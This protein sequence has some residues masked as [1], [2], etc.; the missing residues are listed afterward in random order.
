MLILKSYFFVVPYQS[1]RI[2][3]LLRKS[4]EDGL[5]LE[6]ITLF[7]SGGNF[8]CRQA[9]FLIVADQQRNPTC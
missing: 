5:G 9:G 1:G 8:I 3:A 4:D 7:H 6:Q 2:Q